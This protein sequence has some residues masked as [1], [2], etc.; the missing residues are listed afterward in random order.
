MGERKLQ[1]GWRPGI[2]PVVSK[3]VR[4]E[5]AWSSVLEQNDILEL[6]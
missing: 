1:G 5:F 3:D 2:N 4:S 6:G